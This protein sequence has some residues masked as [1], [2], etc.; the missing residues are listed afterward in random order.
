MSYR[1]AQPTRRLRWV[2]SILLLT[3]GVVY[4]LG[5]ATSAAAYCVYVANSESDSVSVIDT[6]TNTVS[7]TIDV[8]CSTGGCD[9]QGLALTPGARF[10]YIANRGS[11]DGGPGN[12]VS[13][14]DTATNT[15]AATVTVDS[16]PSGIGITPNGAFV[17]V[18]NQ[19]AGTVAVIDTNKALTDPSHSVIKTIPVGDEPVP[20]AITPDGRFAYVSGCGTPCD[21][22]TM[23]TAIINTATNS[24]QT[25]VAG[26]GIIP[27]IAPDGLF[28]YVA[29]PLV[30]AVAV[31]DTA[32]AL[33]D[34]T[35]A[36][37]D[38]VAV[39]DAPFG[40][41]FTPDGGFAYVANCGEFCFTDE[42]SAASSVSVIDT[43]NN[44]VAATVHLPPT[45]GPYGIALTPNGAFAY[46][47]NAGADSVSVLDTAKAVTDPTHA[48]V[49]PRSRSQ[50]RVPAPSRLPP[51]RAAARG[52]GRVA[53]AIGRGGEVTVN[54]L[55]SWSMSPSINCRSARARPVMEI[56]MARS[57]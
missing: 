51:C 4:G 42:P 53:W 55:V 5:S 37:V 24:V 35:R 36:V 50:A 18:A 6:T 29:N 40:V 32:K 34:P 49:T 26:L 15:L 20:V 41:A 31:V 25:T 19:F 10:L 52:R 56:T 22:S 17:Y 43:A 7:A 57:R 54:E 39:G 9:P 23:F 30:D 3:G 46:V 33:T 14:I 44:T 21:T 1:A 2:R 8:H 16:G 28:A 47:T 11:R 48:V 45:N 12:T 27:A 13:V 38:S